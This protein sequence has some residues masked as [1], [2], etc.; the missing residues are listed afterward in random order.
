MN[1]EERTIK[2]YTDEEFCKEYSNLYIQAGYHCGDKIDDKKIKDEEEKFHKSQKYSTKL[3]DLEEKGK[4]ETWVSL[5]DHP[6]YKNYSVSNF[7]RVK[8]YDKIIKQD[9]PTSK[10]YLK[11]DPDGGIQN[12]DHHVNVYTLIA[13]GFLGKKIGDHYDVHHKDNNGYDCRPDN[14]V[15]LTRKQH[16]AVHAKDKIEDIESF[17]KEA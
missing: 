10:G 1:K 17:L 7:G 4:T 8:F 13:M 16:N 15:L 2:C 9:D 3:K 11:L 5:K 12:I 6:G 14:L